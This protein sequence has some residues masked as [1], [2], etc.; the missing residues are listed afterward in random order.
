MMR[1]RPASVQFS[2]GIRLWIFMAVC[3]RGASLHLPPAFP[4]PA[5]ATASVLRL[6]LF[7]FSTLARLLIRQ[8]A[9]QSICDTAPRFAYLPQFPNPRSFVRIYSPADPCEYLFRFVRCLTT[10]T[11][12]EQI[13]ATMSWS[14][15]I[16][17]SLCLS[18]PPLSLS[19]SLSLSRVSLSVSILALQTDRWDWLVGWIQWQVH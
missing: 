18:P 15:P 19:L 11:I 2:S 5:P 14:E 8:Q 4:P 7:F 17:I 13:D 10:V 3:L 12:R 9:R 6:V 1:L 16:T